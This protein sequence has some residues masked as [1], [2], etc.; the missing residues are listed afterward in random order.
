VEGGKIVWHALVGL[1]FVAHGLVTVAIWG[2]KYP[3]LAEG[4]LQPPNPAHSWLLGDER[5]LSMILGIAVGLALIAAGVGFLTD[6]P[7]WPA[8][9][10]TAAA[11]SLVLFAVFFT[12]WWIIGIGVSVALLFAGLHAAETV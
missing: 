12:P 5:F 6:Q 1:L 4:Q 10:V 7:W 9:G 8:V 3:A 2:P 11:A